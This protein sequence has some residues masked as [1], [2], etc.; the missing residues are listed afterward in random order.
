VTAVNT[1]E[2]QGIGIFGIRYSVFAIQYSV[3]KRS[4]LASVFPP[5]NLKVLGKAD[6]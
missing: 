3:F 5:V 6:F 4:I 2:K 1:M